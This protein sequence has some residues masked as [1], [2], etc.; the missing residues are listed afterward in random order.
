MNNDVSRCTGK[1]N[2]IEA[3]CTQRD[4]CARYLQWRDYDPS[5]KST[6]VSVFDAVRNCEYKIEV[7]MIKEWV[8]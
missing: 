5:L 3:I 2:G 1:F 4:T 8:K 7:K 6:W